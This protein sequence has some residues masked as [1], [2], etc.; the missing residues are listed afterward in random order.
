MRLET[1]KSRAEFDR[2]RK[3]RKWVAP[4]FILQ[5]MPRAG[6]AAEGV[7]ARFG[8]A[9]GSKAL[10][11]KTPG[12]AAKRAGAVTRNRARRRLKEAVRLVAPRF[13]RPNYDYV[14]IGRLEALHQ[15]FDDLL[16]DVQLAFGKVHPPPRG[17][18]GRPHPRRG[19]DASAGHSQR[20]IEET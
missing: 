20:D 9:V 2:L 5:A 11:V 18:D 16:E 3:G 13:A 7:G 8:F 10:T 12:A 6:E 14:V 17:S 19:P 1:L 15:G 4:S